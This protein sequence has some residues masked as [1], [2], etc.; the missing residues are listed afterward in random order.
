MVRDIQTA[1]PHLRSHIDAQC[2]QDNVFDGLTEIGRN[3]QPIPSLAESWKNLNDVTW[4]FK[5]RPGVKFHN[6]EDFDAN[7]VKFNVERLLRPGFSPQRFQEFATI[8]EVQVIDPSTARVITK[9]P[10]PLL[11]S[12]FHLV[13]M[14]PQ[15]Y[16]EQ[17]GDDIMNEKPVGTGP[18]KFVKWVKDDYVE[19]EAVDKHWRVGKPPAKRVVQKVIPTAAP[20]VAA[21]Q[22]GAAD[23][24]W[25]VPADNI[26]P[27]E[28]DP[29]LATYLEKSLSV[30]N[31][32]ISQFLEGP[33]RDKRV[34]QAL[35]Y[36]V[37]KE[38]IVKN[39]FLGYYK[40]VPSALVPVC[41]GYDETQK[42]YPY[43][44]KKAKELLAQAGYPNGF[45]VTFDSTQTAY[46]KQ[47]EYIQAVANYL[48]EVGVKA[49]IVPHESSEQYELT[50]RKGNKGPTG[51]F[52]QSP[53][54][55]KLD[56]DDILWPQFRSW[57]EKTAVGN[58][59]YFSNPEL[60]K[61]VDAGR[62]TLDPAERKK[63]YQKALQTIQDEAYWLFLWEMPYFWGYSKKKLKAIHPRTYRIFAWD[64]EPA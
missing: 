53:G 23:I 54:C 2:Y 56:G 36:A 35:N 64:V 59:M 55:L 9:D 5:L 47:T 40:V 16:V 3:Y 24:I 17:N 20:R 52:H 32:Q 18:Y 42:S 15:Q 19:L 14:V 27:L 26:A 49:K 7:T 48:S 4:E 45:E 57:D 22:T 30:P 61:L 13:R 10:D 46:P 29:N 34:R 25:D 1:D 60:D 21:L 33:L 31:I 12:R 58:K 44:P 39:L 11:L 38:S 41:F 51:I 50:A 6:G 62:F 63:I 8:K 28:K 37:D 43:D